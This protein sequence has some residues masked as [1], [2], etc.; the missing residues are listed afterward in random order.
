MQCDSAMTMVRGVIPTR[1]YG[2]LAECSAHK[3]MQAVYISMKR[4][5]K[6]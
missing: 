3:R 4:A 1:L 2:N 5:H 6:L